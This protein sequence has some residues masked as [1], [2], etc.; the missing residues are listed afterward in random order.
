MKKFIFL[1]LLVLLPFLPS[2]AGVGSISI[3]E[4]IPPK[5][6]FTEN[7][8]FIIDG[9]SSLWTENLQTS[10]KLLK[11]SEKAF[12][13]ATRFPT[14]GM[15]FNVFLFAGDAKIERHAYR[16]WAA[17][18]PDEFDATR[19]W[20]SR[21]IGWR[22][23]RIGLYSHGGVSISEALRQKK[24]SLT[25]LM[26]TDGGFTSACTSPPSWSE[27]DQIIRKEQAWRVANGYGQA[28]IVCIG[29]ENLH[30]FGGNKPNND[31]CQ[32][33]LREIG[34]RYSGGYWY[35]TSEHAK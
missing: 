8:T 29:I 18:Y 30:Y 20:M 22:D 15:M 17:G 25:I 3:Q 1:L 28:I 26:I 32:I 9:S 12:R 31:L 2:H 4:K 16:D 35:V 7:W 19:A 10:C 34:T 5:V 27:I 6:R 24:K 14:D 23:D 33:Y 11:K 21:K 13:Y